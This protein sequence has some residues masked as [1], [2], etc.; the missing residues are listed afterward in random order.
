MTTPLDIECPNLC[1]TKRRLWKSSLRSGRGN[2]SNEDLGSANEKRKFIAFVKIIINIVSQSPL[3]SS[4]PVIF[5]HKNVFFPF[6]FI[7]RPTHRPQNTISF[8][9]LLELQTKTDRSKCAGVIFCRSSP[10]WVNK[11]LLNIVLISRF[12][13]YGIL[14]FARFLRLFSSDPR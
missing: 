12:G 8:I 11:K 6:T 7:C 4:E 10:T 14:L 2:P 13:L 1:T 5:I 9:N 3:K